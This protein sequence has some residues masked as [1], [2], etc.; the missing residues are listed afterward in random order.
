MVVFPAPK[1]SSPHMIE[2]SSC[3]RVYSVGR[4][5]RCVGWDVIANE[6][7]V[8]FEASFETESSTEMSPLVQE[9]AEKLE[10]PN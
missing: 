10:R 2:T 4:L 7:S 1:S 8:E 3:C 9:G 5:S 6:I